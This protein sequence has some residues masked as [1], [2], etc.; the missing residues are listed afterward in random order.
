MSIENKKEVYKPK[1]DLIKAGTACLETLDSI[2][3]AC[4]EL[5]KIQ[6]KK[7]KRAEKVAS[8]YE[9]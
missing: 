6:V 5:L 2:L 9:G 1:E 7:E 4:H 3:R 8:K